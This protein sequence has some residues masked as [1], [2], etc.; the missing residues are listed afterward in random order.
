[1]PFV[2]EPSADQLVP[3]QRAMLEALTP[4]ANV[5]VP[6]ATR[7]PFGSVIRAATPPFVP[8]PS[9]DQLV[10]SQRAMRAALTPPAKAKGPP[11]TDP[12]LGSAARA[13]PRL[14][15]PEAER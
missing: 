12:T 4:P 14:T 3:F 6:P 9:A 15:R 13:P 10:P 11:P 7:S 8:E 5:K 2:P 1:M